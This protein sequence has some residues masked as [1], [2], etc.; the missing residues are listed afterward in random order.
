MRL[1]FCLPLVTCAAALAA[2]CAGATGTGQDDGTGALESTREDR[3]AAEL[4]ARRG[5]DAALLE[6]LRA[7]PKGGDLH[8]HLS[9]AAY[10]ENLLSYARAD[11]MCIDP[12]SLT[13]VAKSKCSA[14][15]NQA[16]PAS[17]E[18]AAVVRAW[19]MEGFERGGAE[20]GHD[21]F[22]AAF[23]K[24]MLATLSHTG[25]MLAEATDRAAAQH[26]LYLETMLSLTASAAARVANDVWAATKPAPA[27]ADLGD[28]EAKLLAHPSWPAVL[29][30][31]SRALDDAEKRKRSVLACDGPNAHAGCDVTV[32]YLFQV[33]RTRAPHEVFAQ[34]VAARE[35]AK[36][37]PRVVGVNL[38]AAEDGE[39]ALRDYALHMDMLDFLHGESPDFRVALHAGELTPRALPESAASHLKFHVRMAVEKGHA[40]RIGHAVDVRGE[41][42]ANGLFATLAEKG[43]LVEACLSSND[44]ILE[45]AGDAH[46]IGALVSAH[47][48]VALATDDE[49][50]SRSDLSREHL[51]AVTAQHLGYRDLKRMARDSLEHAFVAGTSLWTKTPGGARV[52][53]CAADAPA[54]HAPSTT[55]A[56]LLAK[57]TKAK[58]EWTLEERL[59]AFEA[60]LA[61]DP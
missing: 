16:L 47:V 11:G 5:D 27:R 60:D 53:A 39:V 28:L 19:S 25:D 61:P 59:A 26:A 54:A 40:S 52:A 6:F 33:T 32:R 58:L 57:S 38:S 41:D 48:P 37:D 17:S 7:M 10:A 2:G 50:V 35:L 42:D 20:S 12:A 15:P 4:D 3:V 44:Q 36:K 23:G 51:R 45:I 43:V 46:P 31:A 29:T 49:G 18:A 1:A 9:G 13:L 30:D 56:A 21:H 24:F 34:M 22:F 55:C 8:H 14:S